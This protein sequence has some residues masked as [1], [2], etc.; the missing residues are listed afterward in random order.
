MQ[1]VS[2]AR[3]EE[4]DFDFFNDIISKKECPKYNGYCTRVNRDQGH[5]IRPSTKIVYLPLIDMN[6]SES[7]HYANIYQT[8]KEVSCSPWARVQCLNI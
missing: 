3:A 7:Y 1:A 4:I 8:S 2:R 5:T 6:S